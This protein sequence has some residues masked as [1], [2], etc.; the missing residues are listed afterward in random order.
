[1]PWNALIPSSL[2]LLVLLGLAATG[3]A[4]G[5]TEA[6]PPPER[7]RIAII[8]TGNVGSALGRRWAAAGHDII[9][10]SRSPEAAHVQALLAATGP[11]ASA[12]T[13]AE[14][15]RE[16]D[17]V[18]LAIPWRV[19]EDTVR[20]LGDLS[21]RVVIDPINASDFTRGRVELGHPALGE[22]LAGLAPAAAFVKAL[23]TTSYQN[24]LEPPT[25]RAIT[26]PLAG[27]D[28]Q[29]LARVARLVAELGLSPR[30]VGPLYNA[31][32]LEA[33]G[34]LYIYVNVIQQP[35]VRL[36]YHF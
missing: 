4:H 33:M 6:A 3:L 14:A 21:G 10:G 7:E 29:A 26:V 8:G 27:D 30:V 2:C 5:Q 13:P 20:D 28:S 19:A 1:M 24:M 11:A 35:D 23:N 22:T 12:A 9:Y 17:I 32:Y 36:E 16:A 25:D 15:V 34:N 18:V 31:R